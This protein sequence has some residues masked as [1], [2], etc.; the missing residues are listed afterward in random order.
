[1]KKEPRSAVLRSILAFAL[2]LILQAAPSAPA[3]ASE[4]D[5]WICGPGTELDDDVWSFLLS[6][7][8]AVGDGASYEP[9]MCLGENSGMASWLV[10][11]RFPAEAERN[12]GFF[13]MY[14][15]FDPFPKII[16]ALPVGTALEETGPA[17]EVRLLLDSGLVLDKDHL[18]TDEI[19]E[20][21]GIEKP[22]EAISVMYL[23][24]EDRAYLDEGWSNRIREKEGK[25]K[26]TFTYKKRYAIEQ[27]DIETA[28]AEARADGFS[29]YDERFPAEIDWGYSSMVLSFSSDV[30]VKPPKKADLVLPDAPAAAEMM[31]E[32]MPQEEKNWGRA[33]WG[34][35][36]A[37]TAE[38]VGPIR[39][40]RY[41]GTMG[42]QKVRIEI[43]P[44]PG[45]DGLIYLTE[46][47][48]TCD[49]VEEA[50]G[51]REEAIALLDEMGILIREDS[52][53]NQ[54]ILR[55]PGSALSPA[56]P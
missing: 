51:P 7:D 46:F 33:G 26:Y 53:K 6:N 52:L 50:S 44:I 30:D 19:R 31:A 3:Y 45:E 23:D 13:V 17:C 12:D 20:R 15:L 1:M 29:L 36:L 34:T 39:F 40:L 54:L 47:S 16:R 25:S 4:A 42:E 48:F 56:D 22:Y 35:A 18:L 27:T 5:P 24:T 55:G 10:A 37:G 43:W 41:T 49:T 32:H 14:I 38:S 28:L 9:V 2:I 21:F 11:R 8:A